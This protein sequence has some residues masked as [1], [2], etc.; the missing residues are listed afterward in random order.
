MFTVA[1]GFST[2]NSENFR[3]VGGSSTNTAWT[4]ST[5]S[6]TPSQSNTQVQFGTSSGNFLSG[7]NSAISNSTATFMNVGS[8]DFTI[9]AWIWVPTAR[10]TGGTGT[11]DLIVNNTTNGLG[12]R[13]GNGYQSNAY[14]AI[15]IFQRNGSD[16]NYANVTLTGNTWTHVA[17]QRY[18]SNI[19]FW[20]NGTYLGGNA[21]YKTAALNSTTFANN[22]STAQTI[23]GYNGGE[24]VGIY[25]DELCV[26][27]YARYRRP[28]ANIVVPTQPFFVDQYTNLLMH[29]DNGNGNTTFTNATS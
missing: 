26:S 27:R 17:V 12:V 6:G 13:F 29:F 24:Y 9:E 25:V 1:Q 5:F 21:T 10:I 20:A 22:T 14:K 8:G 18:G 19:S 3:H 28:T 16:G 11:G 15:S 23:G 4:W 2:N 7:N